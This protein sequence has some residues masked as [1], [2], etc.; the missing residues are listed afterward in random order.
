MPVKLDLGS[1]PN[2]PDATWTAVDKYP[3][4]G[5][6]VVVDLGKERW[7]WE[8]GTVDEARASHFVEHLNQIERVHFVNELHRV[9]KPEAKCLLVTPHWCSNR[10]YGDLT[11]QWPPVAEMW[12]YYLD[13]DWR[14]QQAPHTDA[15]WWKDGYTCN[16]RADWGYTFHQA[17][18]SR[19]QEHQ[20]YALNFYKEAAQDMVCT[21]TKK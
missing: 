14:L 11:H 19:Q 9:L 7:P 4:P 15:S 12:F 5:V 8:D 20:I 13:K 17:I 2:K 18:G 6:D 1:G 3:M 21:L 16:F 10:A